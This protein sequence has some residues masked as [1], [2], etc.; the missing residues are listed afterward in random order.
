MSDANCPAGQQ[1][2]GT[3]DRAGTCGPPQCQCLVGPPDALC[4]IPFGCDDGGRCVYPPAGT[5]CGT[6]CTEDQITVSTCDGAGGCSPGTQM[7]CPGNASCNGAGCSGPCSADGGCATNFLCFEGRCVEHSGTPP[8]DGDDAECSSGLCAP[9][10]VCCREKCTQSEALECAFFACT[11]DAGASCV[12]PP[13]GTLC[14]LANESCIGSTLHAGLCDGM[15][16]CIDAGVLCPNNFACNDAGT[17]CIHLCE[18]DL[19]CAKGFHCEDGGEDRGECLQFI[20]G[21]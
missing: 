11:A 13:A 12:Y 8:C 6:T 15:G 19:D 2:G 16:N 10:D 7:P 17:G 20:D 3:G 5:E 14:D 21:G 1:C 18:S 4:S 9:N